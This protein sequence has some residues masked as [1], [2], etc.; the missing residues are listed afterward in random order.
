MQRSVPN[1]SIVVRT[2]S[3]FASAVQACPLAD[4]RDLDRDVGR[5]GERRHGASPSCDPLART[6]GG[7]SGMVE[8]DPRRGKGVGERPRLAKVPPGVCR[9]K[10]RPSGASHAKPARQAPSPHRPAGPPGAGWRVV[11]GARNA[12]IPAPHGFRARRRNPA[13]RATPAPPQRR[14]TLACHDA[15]KPVHFTRR[16]VVAPFRLDI[17]AGRDLERR[18]VAAVVGGQVRAADRGIIAIPEA[19]RRILAEPGMSP[20]PRVPDMV[21]RVDD[22]AWRRAALTIVR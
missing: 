10:R 9:S 16:V 19:D 20:E 12:Q 6:V 13:G 1:S 3:R 5:A 22:T 17:D 21:V 7:Q 8:N 15:G 11:C 2:T 14:Q 18:R 4:P